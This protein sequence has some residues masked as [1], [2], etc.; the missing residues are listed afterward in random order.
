LPKKYPLAAN[1]N[2]TQER[3]IEGGFS[4][5]EPGR[6]KSIMKKKKTDENSINKYKIDINKINADIKNQEK[7]Q[8]VI[9][10]EPPSFDEINQ[11][12]NQ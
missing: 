7:I 12:S 11:I 4:P 8:P 2:F 9:H 3:P 6:P 10:V 1:R 5:R